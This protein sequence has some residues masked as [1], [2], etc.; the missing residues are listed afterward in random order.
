MSLR[1]SGA[2]RRTAGPRRPRAGGRRG[3][4]TRGRR[5]CGSRSQGFGARG[6]GFGNNTRFSSP[7]RRSPSP[8]YCPRHHAPK[9]RAYLLDEAVLRGAARLVETGCARAAFGEPFL[10]KNAAAD[11]REQLPHL[12]PHRR[13]DDPRTTSQ[14]AILG[15]VADRMPHEPEAAA[16]D[17]LDDQLKLVK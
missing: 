9:L 6:S 2:G 11:V 14:V 1:E 5:G 4:P 10:G 7:E 13:A 8:F 12:L 3:R 15:G 16:I 17:Q